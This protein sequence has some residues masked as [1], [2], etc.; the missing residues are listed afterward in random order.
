M[1]SC[2]HRR[3]SLEEW[4]FKEEIEGEREETA[5]PS[6][7]QADARYFCSKQESGA[8]HSDESAAP[9]APGKEMSSL[10]RWNLLCQVQVSQL[11]H[12]RRCAFYER[13]AKASDFMSIIGA[14]TA[15]TAIGSYFPKWIGV[16][17]AFLALIASSLVLVIGAA[18]MAHRH[19]SLRRR[20]CELE[21]KIQEEVDA[22]LAK[23]GRWKR[24]RV[25]IEVDEPPTYWALSVLCERE[26]AKTL[27]TDDPKKYALRWYKAITANFFLWRNA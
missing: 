22:N 20:F 23:V 5:Q 26:L 16:V 1:R 24:D 6:P 15:L 3:D 14:S 25:A 18:S 4:N 13:L 11:Y 27:G 7:F 17:G 19:D 2:S 8:Q 21:A 9:A 12:A 10:D